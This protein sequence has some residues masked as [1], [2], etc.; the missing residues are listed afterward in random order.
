[1]FTNNLRAMTASYASPNVIQ[2]APKIN[3]Y[4]EDVFSL[5][6]TFLQMSGLLQDNN[7]GQYMLN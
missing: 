1:M 6:M 2:N 4:L 5:G 3:H 7:L